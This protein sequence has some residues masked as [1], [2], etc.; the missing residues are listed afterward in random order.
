M[1]LPGQR[2]RFDFTHP[3]LGSKLEDYRGT[4]EIQKVTHEIQNKNVLNQMFFYSYHKK[5]LNMLYF[6][7]Y[8]HLNGRIYAENFCGLFN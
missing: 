7:I 6:I 3:K 4:A 5:Q 1:I 8:I 2:V